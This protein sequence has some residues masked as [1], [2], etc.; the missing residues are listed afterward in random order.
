MFLH[1]KEK[2]SLLLLTKISGEKKYEINLLIVSF[3]LNTES[4][5]NKISDVNSIIIYRM[6]ACPIR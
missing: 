6:I 4:T 2:H 1:I 5:V 3:E